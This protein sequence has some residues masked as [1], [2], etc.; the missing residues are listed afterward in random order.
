[1]SLNEE[2]AKQ[3]MECVTQTEP[4]EMCTA[5]EI[6]I[7]MEELRHAISKGKLHKAPGPDGIGLEF[8]KTV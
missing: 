2:N 5:L 8:Y 4:S 3:M 7:N 6:P 1:M